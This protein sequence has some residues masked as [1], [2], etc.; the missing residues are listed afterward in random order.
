MG[1]APAQSACLAAYQFCRSAFVCLLEVETCKVG[2]GK[3]DQKTV[4]RTDFRGFF[5]LDEHAL[6]TYSQKFGGI[7][8]SKIAHEKRKFSRRDVMITTFGNA[9]WV[10]LENLPYLILMGK[11]SRKVRT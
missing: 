2:S 5:A 3:T 1:V 7:A 4:R 11:K 9:H 8:Q 6:Y 10:W